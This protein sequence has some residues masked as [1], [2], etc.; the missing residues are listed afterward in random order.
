MQACGCGGVTWEV[1]EGRAVIQS[2][3]PVVLRAAKHGTTI[4]IEHL[5]CQTCKTVY[6]EDQAP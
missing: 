2:E 3:G 4:K 1:K 6:V 5:T